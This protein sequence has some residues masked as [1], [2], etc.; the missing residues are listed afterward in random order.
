[1]T[2]RASRYALIVQVLLSSYLLFD[3]HVTNLRA[4][5]LISLDMGTKE[6]AHV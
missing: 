2:G 6:L 4:I 1:M 3:T 5:A